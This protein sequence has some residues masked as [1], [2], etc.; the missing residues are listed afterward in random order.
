[1][2]I[3]GLQIFKIHYIYIQFSAITRGNCRPIASLMCEG[4]ATVE[5]QTGMAKIAA[6]SQ[7]EKVTIITQCSLS[8][9]DGR[10][11]PGTLCLT[12]PVGLRH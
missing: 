9:W 2:M 3:K 8:H 4:K 5:V 7:W 10:V 12:D 11:D 6:C 1:M